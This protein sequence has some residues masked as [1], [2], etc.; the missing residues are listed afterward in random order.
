MREAENSV[1][2]PAP[3]QRHAGQRCA[4]D[5]Q[6]VALPRYRDEIAPT[7]RAG[8][9]THSGSGENISEDDRAVR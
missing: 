2:V 9:N 6:H 7:F 8:V 5:D 4:F 3:V 1:R